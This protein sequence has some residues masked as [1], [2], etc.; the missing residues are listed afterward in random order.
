[1]CLV[2]S[3]PIYDLKISTFREQGAWKIMRGMKVSIPAYKDGNKKKY[4]KKQPHLSR[5]A[6][7]ILQCTLFMDLAPD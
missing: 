1:M 6:P 3:M 5:G 7:Y 2:N 4:I